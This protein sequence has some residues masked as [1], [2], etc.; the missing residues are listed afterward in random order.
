M[1]LTFNWTPD[2]GAD[3]QNKARV[4][5]VAF[6]DGYDLRMRDGI[7]SVNSSW[8][9]QFTCRVITE[10]HAIRSFLEAHGGVDYFLFP[11][12]V[13]AGVTHKVVCDEW[14]RTIPES[15]GRASMSA[16]FRV[17]FDN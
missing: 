4:R 11:D 2:W 3:E 9:V 6:G 10:I 5:K 12:P 7:N 13:D 15:V 16:Q 14:S 8:S 17:V 1:A